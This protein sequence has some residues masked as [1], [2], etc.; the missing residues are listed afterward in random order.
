[1]YK[2]DSFNFLGGPFPG[3][4]IEN[5]NQE[6][7]TKNFND[8]ININLAYH[9]IS[10]SFTVGYNDFTPKTKFG[11]FVAIFHMIDASFLLGFL[12]KQLFETITIKK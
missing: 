9:T 3:N 2:I 5:K 6:K 7:A 11:K 1:M 8:N 12:F 4:E 10:T